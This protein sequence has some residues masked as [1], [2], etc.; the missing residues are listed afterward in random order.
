MPNL[1]FQ[2]SLFSP[3]NPSSTRVRGDRAVARM[4]ARGIGQNMV[5]IGHKLV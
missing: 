3:L 5:F 1:M 4:D 2:M